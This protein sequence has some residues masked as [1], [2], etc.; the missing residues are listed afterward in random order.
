M[1]KI[2]FLVFLFAAS[3]LQAAEFEVVDQ[4]TVDG[5]TILRS[6]V[7]VIVPNTVPLSLW[8]ST[9]A[10]TPHLY[11]STNGNVGIWTATPESKLEINGTSKFNGI[12]NTNNQ[13]ISGDG[14]AEGIYIKDDGNVGIGTAATERKI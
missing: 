6:S 11:V 14:G 13:W 4:F 12:I 7:Q 3:V 9:S 5:A 1:K 10:I 2:L 8:V